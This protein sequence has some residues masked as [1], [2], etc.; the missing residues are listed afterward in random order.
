VGIN[1]D[2]N[3]PMQRRGNYGGS[4]G[5]ALPDRKMGRR[6][7]SQWPY[8]NRW[9]LPEKTHVTSGI[10]DVLKHASRKKRRQRDRTVVEEWQ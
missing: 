9:S 4:G 7:R 3:K 2:G 1:A 8:F 5:I 6:K 10:R